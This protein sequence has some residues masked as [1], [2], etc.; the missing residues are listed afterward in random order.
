MVDVPALQQSM[1]ARL[2]IVSKQHSSSDALP[3]LRPQFQLQDLLVK[4][5]GLAPELHS[6]QLQDEQFKMINLGVARAEFIL[7]QQNQRSQRI[8]IE[9]LQIRQREACSSHRLSMPFRL[10]AEKRMKPFSRVFV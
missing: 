8:R 1:R 7:L 6:L 3:D 10:F 5:L 2:P 4:L 9:S